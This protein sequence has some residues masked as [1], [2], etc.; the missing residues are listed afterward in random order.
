MRS[1]IL[2]FVSSGHTPDQGDHQDVVRRGVEWL[3]ARVIDYGKF[4]TVSG[5]YMYGHAIATQ[6]LCEAFAYT[7]DPSL[8]AAAQL[9]LDYIAFAQ[10]LG[11]GGWRYN[12]QQ[13]GDTSVVGW[14]VMALNAGFK[15]NLEVVGFRDAI[16]F[17]DAV[18]MPGYYQVG[19][20]H[21]PG[22]A[23]PVLP[24]WTLSDP[25]SMSAFDLVDRN[26]LG[27]PVCE[28]GRE[29]HC[30]DTEVSH[31]CLLGLMLSDGFVQSGRR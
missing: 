12:A 24:V 2:A 9:A 17:L 15:A 6:A 23:R 22:L 16:R 31:R 11:G 26:Q 5:H 20:T 10:D 8:G 30:Q 7:D 14:V 1:T 13:A 28:R 21:R 3:K 4:E 27:R 25:P 18:T 29:Q 19:Y